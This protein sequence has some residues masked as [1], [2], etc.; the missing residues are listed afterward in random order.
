MA[1]SNTK[2]SHR[3]VIFLVYREVSLLTFYF[4]PADTLLP[5]LFG[6]ACMSALARCAITNTY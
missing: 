3:T 4:L 1:R 6:Q 5:G 2:I